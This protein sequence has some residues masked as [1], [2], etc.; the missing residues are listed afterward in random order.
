MSEETT[1]EQT[2]D[3][4][5]AAKAMGWVPQDEFKGDPD[6]HIDAQEFVERGEKSLPLL[7]A[8]QK[9]LTEKVAELQTGI[10]FQNNLHAQETE[11]LVA[12]Y[13]S[14]MRAAVKEGDEKAYENAENAK[15]Q[16][17]EKQ[18]QAPAPHQGETEFAA[19]NDW[20][21]HDSS[22]TAVAVAESQRLM[23]E[24]PDLPWEQHMVRVENHV[25][26]EFPHKYQTE[27]R[28]G[29]PVSAPRDGMN[30]RNSMTFANLPQE[31]KDACAKFQKNK[32]LKPGKEGQEQYLATYDWSE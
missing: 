12:H 19:R 27:T 32:I 24:F 7:L 26:A 15:K 16:V 8:N 4:E 2:Q 3:F 25:K 6:K 29:S 18:R 9:K 11:R 17:E 20:Y 13:E 5:S 10:E 21:K 1:T 28:P 23:A 22:R 30:G 31:A 14:E